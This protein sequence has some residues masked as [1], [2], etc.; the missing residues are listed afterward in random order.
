MDRMQKEEPSAVGKT[1]TD[2]IVPDTDRGL[3]ESRFA[4]IEELLTSAQTSSTNDPCPP[5]G[6]LSIAQQHPLPIT[7]F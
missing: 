2:H 4:S 1:Q 3:E 6:T 7:S 5:D